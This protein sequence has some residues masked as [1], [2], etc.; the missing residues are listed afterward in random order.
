M[1]INDKKQSDDDSLHHTKNY[2]VT[3]TLFVERYR[4]SICSRISTPLVHSTLYNV[5]LFGAEF[6]FYKKT[7][8]VK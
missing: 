6:F 4:D 3:T 2:F 7:G 5:Y 8:I 1:K